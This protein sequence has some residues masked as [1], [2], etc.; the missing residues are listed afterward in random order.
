M[1]RVVITGVGA[2]TPIGIGRDA[3]WDA[4][5]EGRSGI[6]PIS[7]YDTTD[8]AVKIAA[9]VKNLDVEKW[10]D[11]KEARRTDRV[12]HFAIAAAEMAVADAGLDLSKEDPEK[13]GVYVGSGEGGISTTNENYGILRDK[14]PSRVSPFFIPMML[15]NMPAAY[16]AMRLNAKGPNMAVITACSSA[17]HCMGEALHAIRREDADIIF[18]GGAEAA[19]TG[20]AMS[21][22]T[23]MKA[24]SKRNDDPERASRP[25]E[26]DRD[27]FVMGEG[28]GILVFEE[29]EH[30]RARGAHIYAEVVGYGN[31]CDAHH[32]TAPS[33]DGEGLG[34]AMKIAMKGAG[35]STDQVDLY[36]AHGTSTPMNDLTESAAIRGVFGDLA[37][38]LPV[39][40]TK[41]MIGHCLGAAGALET[42][43]SLLAIERGTIHPTINYDTPDPE[44]S[45]NVIAETTTRDV[46]RVLVGN[47]GFGGHN[48][49]LA[50]ERCR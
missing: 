20:I 34:R 38:E 7:L 13:V 6:T 12:L 24:L 3:Y 39:H 29:L 27:G 16:V 25:F 32:I 40:S 33:P 41:S 15:P 1:R 4:L 30:A 8:Y 21:G 46:S 10:F 17:T 14:G 18:T 2:V 35:W 44:C 37:D 43:A 36:N 9:E 19:I 28:S 42:I 11:K 45:V 26:R 5:A 49:V 48:G 22:F 50:I 31:T 47:A 23:V